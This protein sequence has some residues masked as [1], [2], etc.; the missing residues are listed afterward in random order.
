MY[1]GK[2]P[3]SDTNLCY[4]GLWR[5]R[6]NQCPKVFNQGASQAKRLQK[7]SSECC[8]T[9]LEMSG[10]QNTAITMPDF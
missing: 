6:L 9:I 4:G 1:N 8:Y 5:N 7:L 3:Y 10:S 2:P